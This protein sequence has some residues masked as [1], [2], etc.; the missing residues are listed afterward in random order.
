MNEKIWSEIFN[1]FPNFKTFSFF[2]EKEKKYLLFL[3]PPSKLQKQKRSKDVMIKVLT[4]VNIIYQCLNL[5]EFLSI[6]SDFYLI[7]TDP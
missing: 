6:L 3:P 4:D 2:I 1:N 7:L 5:L